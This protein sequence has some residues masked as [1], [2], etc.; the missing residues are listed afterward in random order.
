MIK[1]TWVHYKNSNVKLVFLHCILKCNEKNT[2]NFNTSISQ[3]ENETGI[4]Y[5][6]VIDSLKFLREIKELDIVGTKASLFITVK[7]LEYKTPIQIVKEYPA[8]LEAIQMKYSN[9]NHIEILESWSL[10]LEA[11]KNDFN[12]WKSQQLFASLDRF[13]SF[14][15]KN[16]QKE[17]SKPKSRYDMIKQDNNKKEIAKF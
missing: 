15:V 6:I 7:M 8:R 12:I 17:S 3:I 2:D 9:Q 10:K 16:K 11:E 4:Q 13:Y 5:Q 1:T 14:W